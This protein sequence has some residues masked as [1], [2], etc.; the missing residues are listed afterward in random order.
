MKKSLFALAAL[1]A[2]AS[3]AQA[4]SSVTLYGTFD[5]SAVQINNGTVTQ[6][7]SSATTNGAP[8]NATGSASAP[9]LPL[10]ANSNTAAIVNYQNA[11]KIGTS[12]GLY[13]VDGA[14]FT[15]M[16]GMKGSED[17]GGGL[18]ANFDLQSDAVLN[19]GQTHNSGLFRRSA[20]VGLSGS[21][22]ST[23][24]G[25]QPNPFVES[26]GTLL[27][28][29]GNTVN[30]VRN[31]VRSSGGDQFSN[32]FSYT[33]PLM[34]GVQLK[35]M[36][37][38]TQ[39]SD[40]GGSGSVLAGRAS[41]ESGNLYLSAGYNRMSSVPTWAT[42]TD[43]AT[44]NN[45]VSSTNLW[46]G[47]NLT[48]YNIGAKYKVTPA[49]QV[50]VG[51]W[52][53]NG[54]N[55]TAGT[56]V[57]NGTGPTTACAIGAC[58]YSGSAWAAGI[59]YQATPMVLLGL[60]YSKTSYDSSMWNAQARYSLSKRTTAYFQGSVANNGQGATDQGL[61]MGMYSATGTNSNTTGSQNI[62]GQ[63]PSGAYGVPNTTVTAFG[64]GM[65]HMF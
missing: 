38:T 61:I 24:I 4:Q 39:D 60:N 9:V 37:A 46:S 12:S 42:S 50:G 8:Y 6:T 18:K 10:N 56:A 5:A 36:Y 2:F 30:N 13:M 43:M 15:S 21:W 44:G 55:G 53:A 32:A 23:Q 19:N 47:G 40:A 65:I 64:V 1:G 62:Y 29:M 35:A 48:G 14:I 17:L 27:P 52:N 41:F 63:T 54:D 3:A 16:W 57:S 28:V 22:G 25:R 34:S 20:W 45:N 58:T 26:S 11:G 31:V 33:T 51:Y 49:I 59:G 7:T